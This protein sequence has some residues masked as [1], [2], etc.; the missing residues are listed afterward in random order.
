MSSMFFQARFQHLSSLVV[1][2]LSFLF[3]TVCSC[4]NQFYIR[5]ENE[6]KALKFSQKDSKTTSIDEEKL[7]KKATNY[8]LKTKDNVSFDVL[9]L[10]RQSDKVLVI[11]QGF[12]GSK[13][14]GLYEAGL[15]NDYDVI[16]FDYRWKDMLS[17][18]VS[19][20]TAF[21]PLNRFF[22]DEIE[23]VKSVVAFLKKKKNYKEIVGLGQCYSNFTFVAAQATGK[24]ALFDKLILD[25]CWFSLKAFVKQITLDPWLPG[26]PQ[27]GGA[28]KWLKKILA[29]CA[30]REPLLL[31]SH[32]IVPNVSIE[33]YLST[34]KITPILFIHGIYDLMVPYK[35]TFQKIWKATSSS[36]KAAFVTPFRHSTNTENPEIYKLIC[37]QF[38]KNDFD[39][40]VQQV[41]MINQP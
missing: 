41:S 36:K 21:S 20:Q 26:S 39:Q 7:L 14:D 33:P 17:F 29:C 30:V 1:F 22:Y 34:L 5:L 37:D 3:I 16:L 27:D 10:D 4:D 40:F 13:E 15:F 6:L 31:L 32:L 24:E 19:F 38:I 9:F 8:T 12:P 2:I 23:E 25:S 35:S 28:P 11:G 18:M